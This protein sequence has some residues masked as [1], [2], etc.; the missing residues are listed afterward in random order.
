MLTE[1]DI[2]PHSHVAWEWGWTEVVT[3]IPIGTPHRSILVVTLYM[4]CIVYSLAQYY[5]MLAPA[6]CCKAGR[7]THCAPA[8]SHNTSTTCQ[9]EKN[10]WNLASMQTF[11]PSTDALHWLSLLVALT[12]RHK[13]S[14]YGCVWPEGLITMGLCNGRLCHCRRT[15]CGTRR[16]C[17]R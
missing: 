4:W 14:H 5:S 15:T 7:S 16:L 9:W 17:W 3:W 10:A 1:E 13:A 2:Y 12:E 8:C 11:S 6:F